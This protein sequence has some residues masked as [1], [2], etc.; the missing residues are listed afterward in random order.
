MH[1]NKKHI[2]GGPL[3]WASGFFMLSLLVFALP[4]CNNGGGYQKLEARELA[5]G[6]RNDSLFL[7]IYFGMTRKD[8]FDHCW[9]LYEKG[10][11]KEGITGSTVFYPIKTFKFPASMDFFPTFQEDRIVS[12]PVIFTYNGWAPWNKHLFASELEKEI[13][14]LII[15]WYGGN[16]IKIKEPSSLDG[17]AFVKV[18]GNRRVSI[19]YAD[20]SK[21]QVDFVDLTHV[22]RPEPILESEEQ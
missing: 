15:Q 22:K 1:L 2:T 12:I 13:M 17:T 3:I 4:A 5:S 19:I 6:I 10:V 9:N 8:F 18:D 20:E 21:V 14:D 11:M 16:F 7:G